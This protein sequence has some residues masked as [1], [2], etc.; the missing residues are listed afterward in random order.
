M[1]CKL[2]RKVVPVIVFGTMYAQAED[3]IPVPES[4]SFP[5]VIESARKITPN[6][7][8]GRPF[9][10]FGLVHSPMIIT[11]LKPSTMTADELQKYADI[12]THAYPDAVAKQLPQSCEDL[13]VDKM[14][15]ATVGGLAYVSI[16]ALSE[17]TRKF[18]AT[19][20]SIIQKKFRE[21]GR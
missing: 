13:S 10:Q 19:C 16:H 15:E 8:E 4:W 21:I 2:I 14:N 3:L 5:Q 9:N 20:L 1:K 6:N 12:V 18:A 11:K 7:V 17:S